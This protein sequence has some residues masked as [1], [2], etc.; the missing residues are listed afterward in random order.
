VVLRGEV[1]VN[2]SERD[3]GPLGHV[4]HLHGVIASLGSQ[5][6]GSLND[7][8][9]TLFLARGEMLSFSGRGQR[10]PPEIPSF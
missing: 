7:P 4:A 3:A 10:G 8:I 1:P 2:G 6:K 5:L 9:A